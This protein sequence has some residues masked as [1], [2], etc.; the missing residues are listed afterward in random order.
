MGIKPVK[1]KRHF[2][3]RVREAYR[4]LQEKANQFI[5]MPH[6]QEREQQYER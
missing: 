1:K 6:R 3:K 4:Q 2:V 5:S